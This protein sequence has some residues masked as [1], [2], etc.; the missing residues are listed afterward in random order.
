MRERIL[1]VGGVGVGKSTYA[2]LE[3]ERLGLQRFMCTDSL[4]QASRTGRAH[5]NAIHTPDQLEWSDTS[6]WVADYWLSQNGPWVIEGIAVYRALRKWREANPDAMPPCT[7]VV[8]LT[9][10]KFVLN[11]K[12]STMS[13]TH[14]DKLCELVEEWPELATILQQP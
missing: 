4:A 2:D 11:Q 1:I 13:D 5:P 12:Q 8:W 14:D 6:Q 10:P 7:K 9:D 3:R